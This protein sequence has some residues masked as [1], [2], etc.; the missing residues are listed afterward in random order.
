MNIMKTL[1]TYNLM[2]K[3][4]EELDYRTL[5]IMGALTQEK[6]EFIA[7]VDTAARQARK[8]AFDQLSVDDDDKNGLEDAGNEPLTESHH[9]IFSTDSKDNEEMSIFRSKILMGADEFKEQKAAFL[10]KKVGDSFDV[11]IRGKAHTA[12]IIG[13]RRKKPDASSQQ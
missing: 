10:G 9:V 11:E 3:Q 6:P 4:L 13:T 5:G 1:Q 8:D 12:T 7:Q 2:G